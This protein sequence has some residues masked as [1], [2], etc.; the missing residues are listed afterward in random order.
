VHTKDL[1]WYVGMVFD[2]RGL[3]GVSNA[4]LGV[5]KVLHNA[6]ETT[7]WWHNLRALV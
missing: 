5:D 1:C 3:L 7:R 4:C 2:P 6:L